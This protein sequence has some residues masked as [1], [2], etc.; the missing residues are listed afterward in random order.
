MTKPTLNIYRCGSFQRTVQDDLP[1]LK[2]A[3]KLLSGK[4]IR[5]ID[6]FTQLAL[7]GALTC[8]DGKALSNRTGLFLSSSRCSLENTMGLLDEL[9]REQRFPSP[10]KFVNTVG[11]AANFHVSQQLNLKANSL[12]L[13]KSQF[14]LESML[15]LAQLDIEQQRLDSALIGVVTEVAPPLDT[16]RIMIGANPGESLKESSTWFLVGKDLDEPVLAQCLDYADS[17]SWSAV[18]ERVTCLGQQMNAAVRLEFGVN[19]TQ[20]ERKEVANALNLKHPTDVSETTITDRN[21]FSALTLAQLITAGENN[22][23]QN[24]HKNEVWLLLDS[25]KKGVWS[26]MAIE[27]GPSS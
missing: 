22:T 5:R 12:Y 7:I 13:A 27:K 16:Y 6:R 20:Q 26:F 23:A 8:N 25:D 14:A 10:F 19:V 17:I 1:P 24:N 4:N 2:T 11:N 18:Y 15:T 9:C 21:Q 3:L